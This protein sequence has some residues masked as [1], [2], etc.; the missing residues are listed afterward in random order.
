MAEPAGFNR[1]V[2]GARGLFAVQIL[3]FHLL[4][5]DWPVYPVA[6]TGGGRLLMRVCEYGVELFYCISGYVMVQAVA[7]QKK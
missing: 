2:H 1:Y 5:S 3:V 7:R 4:A 6:S